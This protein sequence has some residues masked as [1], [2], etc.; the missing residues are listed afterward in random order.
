MIL[1]ETDR[2]AVRYF[3]IDDA[4]LVFQYSQEECTKEQLPD[5]VLESLEE[6]KEKLKFFQENYNILT[7]PLVY[8]VALKDSGLLIGHAGFSGIGGGNIEIEY[9]IA[10]AHQGNG[11][12]S[13]LARPLAQWALD[14]LSV[15]TVYGIV[16]AS[17]AASCRCLEKA[18]FSLRKEET[19]DFLGGRCAVRTYVYP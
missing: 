18:G 15:D 7:L 1:F 3:S 5:E 8:A 6:T 12:A 2:L 17:N 10:T 4:P 14:T 16:K 9:A 19:G 11:Y 13:E